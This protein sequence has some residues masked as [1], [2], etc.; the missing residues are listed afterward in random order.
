[1]IAVGR[2]NVR[3][4]RKIRVE[5]GIEEIINKQELLV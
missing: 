4:Y 2:L 1:M 5:P 3:E